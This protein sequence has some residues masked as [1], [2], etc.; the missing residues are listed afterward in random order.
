MSI[1]IV[2]DGAPANLNVL[3]DASSGLSFSANVPA[4]EQTLALLH[5]LRPFQ[6]NDEP[7]NFN[8]ISN[9]LSRRLASGTFRSMVQ[10]LKD[11]YSGK[12]GQEL[13]QFKSND[14]VINSEATLNLWLNAHEY[15]RDRDKQQELEELHCILP[16]E[17]SKAIFSM[18]LHAKVQAI[19]ALANIIHQFTS[20]GSGPLRIHL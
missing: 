11:H 12:A 18:M 8:K 14:V 19:F 16:L 20:G 17:S 13:I 15:H 5:L 3:Y 7:T 6:L 10:R 9:L 2:R 4:P 1:Q